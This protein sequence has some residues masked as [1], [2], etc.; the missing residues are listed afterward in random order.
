VT[1]SSLTYEA[2]SLT[3]FF[4]VSP[5]ANVSLDFYSNATAAVTG[6]TLLSTVTVLSG[7]ASNATVNIQPITGIYY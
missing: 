5:P 7:A 3:G 4:R 2:N 6:G 1:I